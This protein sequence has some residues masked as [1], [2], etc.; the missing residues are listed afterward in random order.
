[1]VLI[2]LLYKYSIYN[3]SDF[4]NHVIQVSKKDVLKI[5]SIAFMHKYS[6]FNLT[7][8]FTIDL[9]KLNPPLLFVLFDFILFFGVKREN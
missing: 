9:S 8:S 4:L 7:S 3:L 2:G 5:E 6:G 1:M